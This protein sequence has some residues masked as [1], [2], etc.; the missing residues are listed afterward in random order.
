MSQCLRVTLPMGSGSWSIHTLTSAS[1]SSR[2]PSGVGVLIPQLLPVGYMG[3]QN[4]SVPGYLGK[5]AGRDA[6]P[7][8]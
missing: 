5:P 6:S 7:D 1:Q 3:A 4:G 2:A 8:S